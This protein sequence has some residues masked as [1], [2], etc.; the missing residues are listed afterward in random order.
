MFFWEGRLS[1][2]RVLTFYQ[3]GARRP[4]KTNSISYFKKKKSLVFQIRRTLFFYNKTMCLSCKKRIYDVQKKTFFLLTKNIFLC[5]ERELRRKQ[6]FRIRKTSP[7]RKRGAISASRKRRTPH[8]KI[9]SCKC[10]QN[11][12]TFSFLRR[13]QYTQRLESSATE[14]L[15]ANENWAKHESQVWQKHSHLSQGLGGSAPVPTAACSVERWS[16]TKC[17]RPSLHSGH[18]KRRKKPT[19]DCCPRSRWTHLQC[20]SN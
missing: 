6:I 12:Y 1:H 17:H 19:R 5:Q 8:C 13:I 10:P 9:I 16:N 15:R 14:A 3:E 7:L 11:E 2:D 18:S 4:F 20:T